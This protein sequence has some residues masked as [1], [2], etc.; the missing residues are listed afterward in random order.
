MKKLFAV[1]GA[2]LALGACTTMGTGTGTIGENNKPVSFAWKSTDGGTSGTMSATLA[3]GKTFSGP[4]VQPTNT[5]RTDEY[6]PM[7]VGW[8]YGWPD[9]TWGGFPA[10]AF[11]TQYSGRVMANLQSSDGK[12][13]RCHFQLNN[14]S[15]GIAAGGQGH[16]QIKGGSTV[17]AVFAAT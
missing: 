11:T 14:P 3:D 13:M 2:S 5:T 16:C 12:R 10:T 4:Y 6:A 17:D 8:N 9:W 1:L 15:A 7:W